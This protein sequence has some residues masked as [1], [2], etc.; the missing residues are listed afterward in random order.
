M[1]LNVCASFEC[2]VVLVTPTTYYLKIML[3]SKFNNNFIY[4]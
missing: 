2:A 3:T 1:A 4:Y